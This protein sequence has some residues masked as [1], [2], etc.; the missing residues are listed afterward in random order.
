MLQFNFEAGSLSAAGSNDWNTHFVKQARRLEHVATM[1]ENKLGG[2]P[3]L[4]HIGGIG[5][6]TPVQY[7]NQSTITILHDFL[8]LQIHGI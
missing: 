3:T 1:F 7:V 4:A 2:P 8:N 5:F 6:F